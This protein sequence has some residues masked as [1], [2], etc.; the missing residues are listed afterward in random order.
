MGG[1]IPDLSFLNSANPL[2][3]GF[4]FA[5]FVLFVEVNDATFISGKKCHVFVIYFFGERLIEIEHFGHRFFVDGQ[6]A[7][8]GYLLHMQVF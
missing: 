2:E 3:D 7:H 6:S 5:G 1:L 4:E 8:G